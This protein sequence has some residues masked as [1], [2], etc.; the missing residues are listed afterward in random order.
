MGNPNPKFKFKSEYEGQVAEKPVSVKLPVEVDQFVRS[1][2]N[3]TEWLRRVIVEAVE[4]E[5][6]TIE[7]GF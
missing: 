3:R 5:Q 7:D 4:R 2:P 1:L 6:Q